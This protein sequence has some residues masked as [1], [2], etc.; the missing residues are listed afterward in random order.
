ML[1]NTPSAIKTE[2]GGEP[3]FSASASERRRAEAVYDS[4]MKRYKR[5]GKFSEFV[6]VTPALAEVILAHNPDNRRVSP[7][8]LRKLASDMKAGNF[9]VNGESVVISST[10]DL[11]DGQHRLRGCIES[12]VSFETNLVV[13]VDRQS[14]ETLDQGIR[15]TPGQQLTMLGYSDGNN[16]AHA[17]RVY[18]QMMTYGR[19]SHAPELSPSWPQVLEVIEDHPGL[20]DLSYGRRAWKAK[21]GGVGLHAAMRLWCESIGG[22]AAGE[23]FFEPVVTNLGFK[24]KSDPS[25]QLHKRLLEGDRLTE[26]ERAAF[27][28]KAWNAF[29]NGQTI[30]ILRFQD[31]ED[32]PEAE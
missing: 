26:T 17:G 12:G 28:I 5:G 25:Y 27:I 13:G 22:A 29:R 2:N 16:L 6:F 3:L 10:G 1:L 23:K 15:R 30:R 32:F 8:G 21:L 31:G 14:R 11:N 18:W 9:Q 4:W 20:A 19:V 24:G 7:H